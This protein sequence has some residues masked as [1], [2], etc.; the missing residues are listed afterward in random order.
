MNEQTT[1]SN[2]LSR[3]DFLKVTGAGIFGA[4][5][6]SATGCGGSSGG[7][8]GGGKQKMLLAHNKDAGN[9]SSLGAKRFAKLVQ[10]RTNGRITVQVQGSGQLG[11]DTETLQSVQSGSL[12]L[13]ANSQGPLAT[14]VK[15]VALFGLP[16]LFSEP[17]QAYKVVDGAVGE[18]MSKLVEQEGQGLMLLSW[19]DN[20]LR[21]VTNNVRPISEPKDLRGIKIRTPEDSMTIDIFEALGANPN[22]LDFNELYT[23]LQQGTVDAQENPLPN[24][25]SSKLQEVQKYLSF[26]N[27]K[28]ETTPL[29]I[30]QSTWNQLSSKDQ[31]AI[32]SAA[33][34]AKKFQRDSF[35][36]QTQELRK[37][38][39]SQIKMNDNVDTNAFRNATQSV[40]KKWSTDYGDLVSQL[41]AAARKAS[42][43][44]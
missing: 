25:A 44:A 5:L 15:Q 6:L 42:S 19:W 16:F 41:E 34:D 22:P 27:H 23:A 11:S 33:E 26:T 9:P 13:T 14:V 8:S 10:E 31:K 40:Y 12:A 36:E 38:F 35:L 28:Y 17:Q 2:K 37:Q 29:L 32:R 30:S 18:K 43:K 20:G 7:S 21:E 1:R 39:K 24:I 4:G 3:R